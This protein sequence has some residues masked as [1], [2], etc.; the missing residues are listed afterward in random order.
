MNLDGYIQQEM[1]RVQQYNSYDPAV[2]WIHD[3]VEQLGFYVIPVEGLLKE[4]ETISVLMHSQGEV[5]PKQLPCFHNHTYFELIYVYKGNC[6]NRFQD[7]EIELHQ[8]DI[9]L[10][11][12]N[13]LHALYVMEPTDY[14]FNLMLSKKLF[15]TSMMSLLSDNK[16]LSEFFFN[17]LYQMNQTR[18]Y[19][20]FPTHHNPSIDE[21][22][23]GIIYEY[24]NKQPFYIKIM[25]S[26]LSMLFG[27]LTR[28]YAFD[29]HIENH[30][31]S[32]TAVLP[33]MIAYINEHYKDITLNELEQQFSYSSNYI[34]KFLKKHTGQSFS[35]L[36]CKF[37]LDHACELLQNTNLNMSEIAEIVGFSD[38]HYF[39]K[40]FKKR[41]GIAP[42]QYRKGMQKQN[43]KSL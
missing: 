18:D 34:S 8:G 19:I 29:H 23:T 1:A 35:E 39:N 11:N 15:E 7:H 22:V 43:G 13:V 4:G 26:G 9:L 27:L 31:R 12:P 3:Q 17:Y 38:S 37:R 16:F 25:E 2:T 30:I 20:Y 33:D 36:V 40:V 41:F 24:I 21:T 6:I 5:P 28:Q 10:L 14:V 32:K 42:S